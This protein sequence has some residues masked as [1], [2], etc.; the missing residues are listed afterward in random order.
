M[1]KQQT[2]NRE[3]TD[4]KQQTNNNKQHTNNNNQH[5]NKH[6]QHTNNNKQPLILRPMGMV[7]AQGQNPG[8]GGQILGAGALVVR[9]LLLIVLLA[10]F[11]GQ[12][13]LLYER[14]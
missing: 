1:T 13:L 10:E 7:A 14:C 9:L 11:M 3:T 2:T 6:K 4:E 8:M 5:T 12:A